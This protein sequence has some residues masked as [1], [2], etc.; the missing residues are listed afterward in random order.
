ML[1]PCLPMI[2][3]TL[4]VF[5]FYC[6]I[7]YCC[8]RDVGRHWRCT[9]VRK[10]LLLILPLQQGNGIKVAVRPSRYRLLLRCTLA[11]HLHRHLRC[12]KKAPALPLP[13]SLMTYLSVMRARIKKTLLLRCISHSKSAVSTPFLIETVLSMETRSQIA[14]FMRWTIPG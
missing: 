4:V 3:H 7:S 1:V 14:L 6:C 11:K 12:R 5:P 2:S 10:K 13:I 9:L 8:C